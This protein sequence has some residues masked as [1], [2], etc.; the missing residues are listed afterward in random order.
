MR[1]GV[2]EQQM[3]WTRLGA[4]KMEE[5]LHKPVPGQNKTN[6]SLH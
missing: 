4:L 3:L 6:G 2:A 5:S 1:S